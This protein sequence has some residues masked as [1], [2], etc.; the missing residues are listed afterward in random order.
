MAGKGAIL[1]REVA[2]TESRP[3]PTLSATI[4]KPRQAKDDQTT[5]TVT[6]PLES[7]NK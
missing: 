5:V 2:R 1:R 3:G 6:V 7:N 4:T